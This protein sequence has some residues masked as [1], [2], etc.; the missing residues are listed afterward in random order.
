MQFIACI[1]ASYGERIRPKQ[2][3]R[4]FFRGSIQNFDCPGTIRKRP[5]GQQLP[6]VMQYLQMSNMRLQKFQ[7][8]AL[9][10]FVPENCN[11]FHCLHLVCRL[12]TASRPNPHRQ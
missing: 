7:S 2:Q 3:M 11:K 9:T 5:A 12:P 1:I 10:L 4:L 6:P 8:E